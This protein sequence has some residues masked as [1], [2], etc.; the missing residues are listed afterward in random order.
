MVGRSGW[1][2]HRPFR[3]R[4]TVPAPTSPAPPIPEPDGFISDIGERLRPGA[5][6]LIVLGSTDARDRII[7]RIAPYGG[8]VVQTSLSKG[9]QQQLADAL[10]AAR[11]A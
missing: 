10:R 9:E 3:A 7:E 6:A 5:A 1:L 2:E 4:H 8:T 11:P